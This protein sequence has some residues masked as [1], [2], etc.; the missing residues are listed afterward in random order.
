MDKVS[1]ALQNIAFWVC[2]ALICQSFF[3]CCIEMNKTDQEY[4]FKKATIQQAKE[5]Q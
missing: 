2:L 4:R 5:P 1:G 3:N